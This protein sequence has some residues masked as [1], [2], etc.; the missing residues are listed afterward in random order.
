MATRLTERESEG[1]GE[2]K[3]DD[4]ER[5]FGDGGIYIEAAALSY[6]TGCH[7]CRQWFRSVITPMPAVYYI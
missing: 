7:V 3:R 1:E 6:L 4:E 5:F 2:G